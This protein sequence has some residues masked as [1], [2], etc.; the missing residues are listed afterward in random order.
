MNAYLKMGL[1]LLV[2]CINIIMY[3]VYKRVENPTGI[4]LLHFGL[5]QVLSMYVAY[6][7]WR[8]Y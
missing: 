5:H 4:T 6:R 1:T 8:K 7:I 3:D 2:I